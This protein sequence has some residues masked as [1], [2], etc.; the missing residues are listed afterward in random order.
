LG[1]TAPEITDDGSYNLNLFF[2]YSDFHIF[3]RIP[4]YHHCKASDQ[5]EYSKITLQK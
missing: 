2:V 4:S 5:S 3:Q 1:L